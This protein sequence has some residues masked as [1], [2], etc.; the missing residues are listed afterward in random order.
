MT[1]RL[2]IRSRP[3]ASRFGRSTASALVISLIFLVLITIAIVGFVTT[4]GLERK[5]VQSHFA[6]VQADLYSSMAVK[7]AASRITEA[8]S[9]PNSWW[10]SQPGRIAQTGFGTNSTVPTTTFVDLTSGQSGTTAI[11]DVSV[12]LNRA[13]LTQG[14]GLIAASGTTEMLVTWIYVRRDGSQEPAAGAAPPY[15]QSNP[16]VGRY[17]YWT[18]DESTRINLNTAASRIFPQ[19]EPLSHPSRLDLTE[20]E[21]LNASDVQKI[22]SLRDDKI[23]NS[24]EEA[25]GVSGES[26]VG[27]A[28]SANK[29]SLTHYNHSPELNRFGEP[30]IV[31]TT[32]KSLAGGRPFFDILKD[33]KENQDPGIDENLDGPKIQALFAKL[34]PYFEKRAC[35]WGLVYPAQSNYWNKTLLQKYTAQYAAGIILNLIDYVRSAES[36]EKL[37][38]PVRAAFNSTTG[39]L[40]YGVAGY[41]ATGNYGPNAI[42]GNSRRPHIVEM[43]VWVASAPVAGQFPAKLKVRIYLPAT[44]GTEIDLTQLSLQVELRG[45]TSASKIN[46]HSSNMAINAANVEGGG[47]LPAGEYRALTLPVNLTSAT[48]PTRIYMRL[49]LRIPTGPSYDFAPLESS[50]TLEKGASYTVDAAAIPE[51]EMTSLSTSDPVVNQCFADWTPSAGGQKRNR[52]NTQLPAPESKLG[53]PAPLGVP[54]QDSDADGYLTG[55]STILPSPK[56]TLGNMLGMIG[57]VGELGLIHTGVA[58]TSVAGKPWRTLRL[59][60]RYAPN[61][62]LP[63]WVLLDLFT[64]PIQAKNAA[65]EAVFFPQ[66]DAMGGKINVNA[67]LYPFPSAQVSRTTPLRSII[68]AV[69]PSLPPDRLSSLTSAIVDFDGA[70]EDLASGTTT[71]GLAFGTSNFAA[72]GLYTMPAAICEVKGVADAGEASEAT[73]RGLIGFLTTQSNVFSVFAIGQKIQQLPTGAIKVLGE[74]QTRS[75]IELSEGKMRVVSTTEL[76]M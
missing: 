58:G 73:V 23:L 62:T 44:V 55:A 8:T 9:K 75:L 48:R 41:G 59:Q 45:G 2:S 33:A 5:T 10:V 11:P 56:G 15:N 12:N 60:P 6:G 19:S 46:Y 29:E 24:V 38:L 51:E 17:A 67:K 39:V 18:D 61:G 25:R 74:S 52:F 35:D 50:E 65:E 47:P 4:A 54:Q 27:T 66:A 53:Q 28:L 64:V 49:A 1:G 7:V 57:S 71:T 20:L 40:T 16:V 13:S 42:R 69:E 63:D 31:L 21:P 14:T 43:G 30:R 68:K 36:A 26:N 34:Y 70:S 22:R 72:Q 32:Q 3:G 37:V 76:G